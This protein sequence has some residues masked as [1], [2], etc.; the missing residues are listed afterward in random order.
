[1]VYKSLQNTIKYKI[2]LSFGIY[3]RYITFYIYIKFRDAKF[4]IANTS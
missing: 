1:M 2:S 3:I 4:I